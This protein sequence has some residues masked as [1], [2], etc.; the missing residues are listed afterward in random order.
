MGNP[1][2]SGKMTLKIEVASQEIANTLVDYGLWTKE[3]G[4]QPVARYIPKGRR[5]GTF[6][7]LPTPT[8][9]RP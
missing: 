6:P 1:A 3:E 2:K 4:A 5:D 8:R 7:R 9:G